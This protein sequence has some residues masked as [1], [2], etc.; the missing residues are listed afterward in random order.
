MHIN[1]KY[2]KI[3]DPM[4]NDDFLFLKVIFLLKIQVVNAAQIKDNKR[5]LYNPKGSIVNCTIA[6]STIKPKTPEI[7]NRII[8]CLKKTNI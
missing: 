3:S 7:E 2:E 4:D 1:D 6:A 5:L 8:F